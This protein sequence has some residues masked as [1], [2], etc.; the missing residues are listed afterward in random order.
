MSIPSARRAAAS[1]A[2]GAR[3]A[4]SAGGQRRRVPAAAAT[5]AQPTAPSPRAAAALIPSLHLD[6]VRP[7]TTRRALE[8]YEAAQARVAQQAQAD[9]QF[10]LA[11]LT[12]G[13]LPDVPPS[14]DLEQR[15]EAAL[16]SLHPATGVTFRFVSKER[17]LEFT[18]ENDSD[19][20]VSLAQLHHALRRRTPELLPSVLAALETLSVHIEPVFGPRAAEQIAD[21]I[22]NFDW[23]HMSLCD[24]GRLSERASQREILRMAR[25]LGLDHPY[26]VRDTHP[27]LYFAPP[28]DVDALIEALAQLDRTTP[29]G[30]ALHPLGDLLA[31][32]QTCVQRLPDMTDAEVE[33]VIGMCIPTTLYTVSPKA[34][35]TAYEVVNLFFTNHMEGGDDAPIFGLHLTQEPASHQ[36]LVT[37]LQVHQ[38][39]M[40]LLEQI[41]AVLSAA[42]DV[43][44][45][46]PAPK[47]RVAGR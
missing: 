44:P 40:A 33:S 14:D 37:Y 34:Y 22:W 43:C 1:S 9:D 26:S 27:W 16:A 28:L 46:V 36:R 7:I 35:C 42:N 29:W 23:V 24:E 11:L 31:A 47:G 41:S 19:G 17:H 39:G 2:V 10:P 8:T 25:R 45:A 30:V 20:T 13:L 5:Q 18:A 21:Y 6:G 32:L 15:L 3:S 38:E 4:G 12:S